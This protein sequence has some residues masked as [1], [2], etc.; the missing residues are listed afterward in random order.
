M[1]L[2][3]PTARH[4]GNAGIDEEVTMTV[5]NAVA[6]VDVWIAR[7]EDG[8]QKQREKSLSPS[9]AQAWENV[10]HECKISL[11]SFELGIEDL[12]VRLC[13]QPGRWV[14]IAADARRSNRF[15]Q[16]MAFE[17]SSLVVEAAN[18]SMLG[19]TKH[20]LP[21]ADEKLAGRGW[22]APDLPSSPNWRR[23]EATINPDIVSVA[24][25]AIRTLREVF[26]ING[27]GQLL[28]TMFA[29][30]MRGS[31][32]ASE[33]VSD[34]VF[35]LDTGTP[36]RIIQLTTEDWTECYRRFYP[37]QEVVR[38]ASQKQA[39]VRERPDPPQIG[40][41]NFREAPNA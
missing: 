28:L 38:T 39:G 41:D 30:S 27:N 2:R 19:G 37:D 40:A 18:N 12:L 7:A 15:W 14:L 33:C 29:V 24:G 20:L 22:D 1:T 10:T 25:Q 26:E 8:L 6:S 36:G 32:P 21:G 9:S 11:G 16:A 35:D 3:Q 17:D 23:V 34:T 4:G 31:T 13:S 5:S